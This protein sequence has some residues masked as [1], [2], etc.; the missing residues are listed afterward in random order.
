MSIRRRVILIAVVAGTAGAAIGLSRL[1]GSTDEQKALAPSP[2]PTITTSPSPTT[3]PTPP[4]PDPVSLQ[5][6]IQENFDG[7]DL[8]VGRVLAR[9]GAYVRY[10][11]TYKSGKLTISGTMNVPRGAGPFPVVVMNHG[12]RDPATYVNGEGLEREEDSLARHGYVALHVDYRNHAQ[13]GRDPRSELNLGLGYVEDAVNAVLAVKDSSLPYLDRARIGMLGRSMGGGVTLG[14]AV[15]RPDL[16]KAVVV[17]SSVSS[18]TVDNFNRWTRPRTALA[19]E[20][21]AA[22]GSPTANPT[23]WRNV[24]PRT[25]FDRVDMPILM[26]HG[27]NDGSCPLAWSQTTYAALR[28]LHKN[29][30]LF[31]YPG[32]P[33]VF[34][35]A[36]SLAM[37]RTLTF[38]DRYLKPS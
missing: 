11:V 15:V 30:K 2:S 25:F 28:T 27:T 1:V 34:T 12:Y 32:Q 6:L 38:L 16:L 36:W 22:H 21:V 4:P 13:S 35:S 29:V 8:T 5:A 20:I 9:T 33:H 24:S 26:H 37:Q 17:F 19:A 14:A 7:R 10:F 31:E 18:N 23:F 3:S